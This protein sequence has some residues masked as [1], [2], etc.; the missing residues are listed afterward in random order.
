MDLTKEMRRNKT[1][2][3][4]LDEKQYEDKIIEIVRSLGKVDKKICYLCFNKTYKDMIEDLKNQ[5]IDVKK[6]FF[7]DVLSSYYKRQ[8]PRENCIF[9]PTPTDTVSIMKALTKAVKEKG[10]EVVVFD[11]ISTFLIYKQNYLVLKFAYK[12]LQEHLRDKRS[13]LITLR[14]GD[15]LNKEREA[16]IKDLSMFADVSI[17]I[18]SERKKD[19]SDKMLSIIMYMI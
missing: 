11:T 3:V 19:F 10:C 15:L 18:E 1:I 8:E 17:V 4:V 9:I 13:I 12:L 5:N 7:I 16:L 2:L 14:G 6:F